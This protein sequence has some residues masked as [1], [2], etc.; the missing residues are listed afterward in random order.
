M[1]ITEKEA[2]AFHLQLCTALANVLKT[3]MALLGIEMPD[4]M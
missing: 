4:R 1:E 3:G 2:K